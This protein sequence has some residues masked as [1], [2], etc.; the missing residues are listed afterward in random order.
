VG[1]SWAGKFVSLASFPV[2]SSLLLLSLEFR[3]DPFLPSFPTY[4]TY[5]RS[6][7]NS[8][9]QR[10]SHFLSSPPP[11]TTDVPLVLQPTKSTNVIVEG[12]GHL[13][14]QQRPVEMGEVLKDFLVDLFR[15]E[16]KEGRRRDAKL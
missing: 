2:S 9:H 10:V 13:I 14:V 7:P 4:L 15:E 8:D 3:A 5:N 6:G 1:F 16:E 12:A 11:P